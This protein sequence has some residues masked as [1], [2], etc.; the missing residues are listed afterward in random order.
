[1]RQRTC[2]VTHCDRDRAALDYCD[3]HYREWRRRGVAGS[4]VPVR[5]LVKRCSFDGCGR[6][7]RSDG[8]CASHYL[9]KFKGKKLTPIREPVDTTARDGE[10]RKECTACHAWLPVDQFYA[11]SGTRDGLATKC[12][13]CHKGGAIA[14][15]YLIGI[16]EYEAMLEAQ[17]GACAICGGVNADGR[18]LFI[19]HDH[20]TGAVR[21]LLCNRC[22]RGIG[23][24]RDDITLLASA[25]VYLRQHEAS[26]A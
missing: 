26:N 17:G 24:L 3:F 10:G 15:K 14:N 13:R 1:M 22:N 25:I 2:A 23:N 11:N 16:D 6:R 12:K 5:G 18:K 7:S 20:L 4:P 19:D 8:L 21:G 9:Q